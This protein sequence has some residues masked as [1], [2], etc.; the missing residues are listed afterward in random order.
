MT[1]QPVSLHTQCENFWIG[2]KKSI[3]K[4]TIQW[5]MYCVQWSEYVY[6]I[7]FRY[8]LSIISMCRMSGLRQPFCLV[9]LLPSRGFLICKIKSYNYISQMPLIYKINQ[10]FLYSLIITGADWFILHD[11]HCPA[12]H[13]YMYF[14]L[15]IYGQR[16]PCKACSQ[17]IYHCVY[18]NNTYI[19]W[20][21]KY[22]CDHTHMHYSNAHIII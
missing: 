8:L 20:K 2:K 19:Q 11:Y 18:D 22:Y 3:S 6:I 14:M 7:W 4:R 17:L 5:M 1:I 21:T 12:H 10:Y 16:I 9:V 13:A 15:I